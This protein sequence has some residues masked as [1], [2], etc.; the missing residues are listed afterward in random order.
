MTRRV[1]LD[2]NVLLA[3]S[4]RHHEQARKRFAA[5]QSWCT[6]PITEIGLVRLLLRETV[7]VRVVRAQDVRE[8][9]RA[10]RKCPAGNVDGADF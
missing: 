5:I 8:Q 4:L 9:L 6:T 1:L 10:L 7:V 2:V 3:L